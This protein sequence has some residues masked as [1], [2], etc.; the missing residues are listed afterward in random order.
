MKKVLLTL[1]VCALTFSV[2]A[3]TSW[4]QC[5]EDLTGRD[6]G[7]CDSLN[8]ICLDCDKEEGEVGPWS[9]RF[10]F[11]ITHDQTEPG[12]SIA[13]FVIP[14]TLTH[15]NPGAYCSASIW[16]NTTT[17]M[18]LYP[19][20][21]RSI[22]RHM[23]ATDYVPTAD[24]L[25]ANR[26]AQLEADFSSRGWDFIV[27]NLDNPS[28]FWLSIVPLG[29]P[30]QRWWEGDRVLLA[31]MT[32]RISDTMH[33]CMDSTFWPPNTRLSFAR[34]NGDTY[35]PRHNLP[36]CF[37][38]GPP[39]PA[40]FSIAAEPDTQVVQA[41]D[42]TDYDVT[43]TALEGWDSPCSLT[44]SDLPTGA[45]A[46]FD[47]NPATPT[48]T[49][50][51]TVNTLGTTTPETYDLT[52]TATDMAKGA[53]T[54]STHVFLKV[55]PPPDFTIK[56]EPDSQVVQAGFQV[57]SD[58]ILT[59]LEGFASPCSLTISGLPSN[60]VA[61]FDPNPAT[62]T[63]TVDLLIDAG[64]ET[65]P[66][67]YTV[68]VTAKEQSKGIEHSDDFVLTVTP[69]A[70][71]EMA[72]DPDSLE[73]QAGDAGNL[74]VNLTALYGFASTCSLTITGLPGDVS[75]DFDP[76][77]L[78]PPGSSNL[79]INTAVTTTAA[80]CTATVTATEMAK[81]VVQNAQ[82]IL[83]ITPPPDFIIQA[84]PDTQEVWP[85]GSVDYDVILTSLYGFSESLIL[86]VS[87]LPTDA[88]AYFDV[89]P[90]TP[91]NTSVM[92]VDAALTTP[93]G[94]YD[95]TITASIVTSGEKNGHSTQVVLKVL[96]PDFSIAV[97]PDSQDVQAS[98]SVNFDVILNSLN[99][100]AAE[101]SLYI[102]G[103]PTDA[104]GSFD[105]NPIIPTDTSNLLI[106]TLKTTPEGVCTATVTATEITKGKVHQFDL[107]LNVTPPPYFTMEAGPDT[108]EV[109]V[110][111]SVDFDIILTS[112]N[113]Y[114][115]ECWFSTSALPTGAS[116][117]F[118]PTSIIPTATSVMTIATTGVTPPGTYT[119]TV[120]AYESKLILP[121]DSAKV[122]LVIPEPDY[123]VSVS[124]ETLQ[125]VQGGESTYDVT[126]TSLYNFA[127]ECTL[128]V[129]G[130]PDYS[131]GTFD[132][133]TLTPTDNSILT[134]AAADST[135][136]GL[137]MLTIEAAILN[138][139][140]DVEHSVEVY[141]EVIPADDF[142]LEVTPD[143]L[144]I[145]RTAPDEYYY[146]VELASIAGFD[147]PC[148]LE[149]S[150]LPTGVSG[151]FDSPILVPSDD[152]HLLMSADQ[153]APE[154][155]HDLTITA[156]EIGSTKEGIQHTKNVV[157]AVAL[158]LYNFDLESDPD[159]QIV[160]VG[161]Q[162]TFE[163]SMAPEIGFLAPCYLYLDSGM[164][165]NAT[166]SFNPGT[167]TQ[168]TSSILTVTTT[169]STPP[170][171][172]D[173][174]IRG[175]VPAPGETATDIIFVTLIVQDFDIS[176]DPDSQYVTQGQAIGFDLELY[177]INGFDFPCT[178]TVT[179]LP[180][181][182]DSVV[183]DPA[184]LT[185]P[186][187]SIMTVYTTAQ[188]PADRYNLTIT[189]QIISGAKPPTETQKRT[190]EVVLKVNQ[191]SDVD[192]WTDDVGRPNSFALFQNQPN[193]FNPETKIDYY[194]PNASHVS[195]IIYNVLGQRV[196]TLFDDYQEAGTHNLIWDGRSDDG[197]QL[198]SGIYF[199]R[200]QAGTFQ[201]TKK[202]TLMK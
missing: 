73:I 80:V 180:D 26:M 101:C 29:S 17:M 75:A 191:A 96:E 134:I 91:T 124:P 106:S 133:A 1:F 141:L 103:L 33:V 100:F 23:F 98:Y 97:E 89:N 169:P 164:P 25:Y 139:V 194:L 87:D 37:W 111:N 52:I 45:S 118:D 162:T 160:V 38:V 174:E 20:F 119:V 84:E 147:S 47:P 11:L 190:V 82:L 21:N 51:M 64:S 130:L 155:F 74:N 120:Y 163:I 161:D 127:E 27:L 53:I 63:I 18:Y 150:G 198:G 166:Y 158:P 99:G 126:V 199:Y 14:L 202:M 168:V 31:T 109:W 154:G 92:T 172:Y 115:G 68:T 55:I 32:L 128:H 137:R 186:G 178:L 71:F 43:L 94:T 50:V 6:M 62:P 93:P 105:V 121:S 77:T 159:T 5:P 9:V 131:T 22:Y 144:R 107:I 78:T 70:N 58:V 90:I 30:D 152:T 176:A 2:L 49:S 125:V 102:S 57:N 86:D 13:G 41:G 108:Q 129:S 157:L 10:P 44:V 83:N 182:P 114:S 34:S 67:D 15:T 36:E 170:G 136:L 56:V 110:G 156:T 7:E 167:I 184:K 19:D 12:D 65:T 66:G 200:M 148:T 149:V 42:S 201:E 40:D 132:P 165:A 104:A 195:L 39:L 175:V 112:F 46:S 146:E 122:V 48:E 28:N 8:V 135:P 60:T 181:P 35:I 145:V 143:T 189:A 85:G 54:H 179:G 69:A 177:S 151:V 138:G 3:G 197:M 153:T 188:S 117:G 142:S 72:L 116:A 61:Y 183:F 185:P 113:G 24:T 95:L 59:S 140:K 16:W 187:S 88:S 76:D 123:D 4:A 171:V 196:R 173:L 81:G 79:Q 193:P 192:D